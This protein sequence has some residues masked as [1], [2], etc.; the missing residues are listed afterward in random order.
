VGKHDRFNIWYKNTE[1]GPEFIIK[2]LHLVLIHTFA[3]QI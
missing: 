1:T 2:D 3:D